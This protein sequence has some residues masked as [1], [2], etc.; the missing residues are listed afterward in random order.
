MTVNKKI[1]SIT[2]PASADLSTSQHRIMYCASD[3]EAAALTT[4][5]VVTNPPVGILLNKP[6]GTGRAAEIAIAGAVVKLE[7][8]CTVDEGQLIQPT[9]GG[10]GTPITSGTA[11]SV[12]VALDAASGSAAKF[13]CLV[14]PAWIVQA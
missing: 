2:L 8:G 12:G 1:H 13:A 9:T 6:A 5:T 3:G 7:A 4:G 14:Q 11:W 10:R